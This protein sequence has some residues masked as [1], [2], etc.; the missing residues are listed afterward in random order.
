MDPEGP[1]GGTM[2]TRLDVAGLSSRFN[3]LR[4]VLDF[5]FGFHKLKGAILMGGRA[6]IGDDSVRPLSLFPTLSES[7]DRPRAKTGGGVLF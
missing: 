6:A 7:N 4:V 1:L 3:C 5:L 2:G